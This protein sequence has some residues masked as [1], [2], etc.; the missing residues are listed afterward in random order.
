MVNSASHLTVLDCAK[1][2]EHHT[3]TIQHVYPGVDVAFEVSAASLSGFVI[4]VRLQ[5]CVKELQWT[6]LI[7]MCLAVFWYL[8]NEM[9]LTQSIPL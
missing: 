2:S 3:E 5:R 9:Y 1:W 8:A 7:A 6:T 4:Q